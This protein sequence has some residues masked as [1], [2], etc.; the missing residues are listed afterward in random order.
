MTPEWLWIVLPPL[1]WFLWTLGGTFRK[2]FRRFGYPLVLAGVLAA[3]GI[4]WWRW[5]LLAI[6]T[7]LVAHLG[8]G[9]RHGWP[10]RWLV[11]LGLGGS[12]APLA[13]GSP[14]MSLLSLSVLCL[15]AFIGTF[16]LSR[17]FQSFTWK[18]A[19][20]LTGLVHAASVCWLVTH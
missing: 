3:A 10:M 13:V 18:L 5:S 8:Y 4:V 12:L 20:G 7:V 2:S 1:G 19:E 9:D 14:I 6:C 17:R 15:L 11:G 16:W